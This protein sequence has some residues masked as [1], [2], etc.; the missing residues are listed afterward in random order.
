MDADGQAASRWTKVCGS[1]QTVDFSG[2]S[3]REAVKARE[4]VAYS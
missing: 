2:P 3:M 1:E 4:A